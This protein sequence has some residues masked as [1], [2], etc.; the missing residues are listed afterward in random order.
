MPLI[1]EFHTKYWENSD[2]ST[3]PIVIA[4]RVR[5]YPA[6]QSAVTIGSLFGGIAPFVEHYGAIVRAWAS[7]VWDRV[8]WWW[9]VQPRVMALKDEDRLV[10]VKALDAFDHPAYPLARSSVRK[11][12]VKLGFNRPIAWKDLAGELKTSAGLAENTYRHLE[13][14]RLTRANLINSTLTNPECNLLVELAYV[15]F[16]VKGK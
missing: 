10:L 6:W 15:G 11:T 7:R 12:A 1:G 5:Q 13:A 16:T 3:T 4:P 8:S 14:C 9:R 2:T